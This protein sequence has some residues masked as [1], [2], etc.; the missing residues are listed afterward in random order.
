MASLRQFWISKARI[1]KWEICK[2]GIR[3]LGH[4]NRSEVRSKYSVDQS[5]VKNS[6]CDVGLRND[7]SSIEDF[8]ASSE[9]EGVTIFEGPE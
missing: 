3:G 5:V 9:T 7:L 1:E 4:S 8:I 6:V 2:P